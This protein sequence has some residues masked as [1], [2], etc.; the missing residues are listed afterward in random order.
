MV[1]NNE[2]INQRKFFRVNL[3]ISI[4]TEISIVSVNGKTFE[5]NVSCICV[6]DIG[7]GGL[8]FSTKLEL[9]ISRFLYL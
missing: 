5:T 7:I 6:K 2:F 9:P 8:K 4:S 3:N 1:A